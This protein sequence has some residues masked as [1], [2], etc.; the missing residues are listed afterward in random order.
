MQVLHSA[1]AGRVLHSTGIARVLQGAGVGRGGGLHSALTTKFP[2]NIFSDK[3]RLKYSSSIW[4][5]KRA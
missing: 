1:S 2:C 5:A 3:G 4:E